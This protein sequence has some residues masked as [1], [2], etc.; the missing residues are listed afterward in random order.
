MQFIG[1]HSLRPLLKPAFP[2]HD[3]IQLPKN[4]VVDHFKHGCHL[5]VRASFFIAF[6][7]PDCSLTGAYCLYCTNS[8]TK[9]LISEE[10]ILRS[11]QNLSKDENFLSIIIRQGPRQNRGRGNRDSSWSNSLASRCTVLT[12][13]PKQVFHLMTLLNILV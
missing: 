6:P 2:R 9:I 5:Y 8:S 1:Q 3:I 4:L 7:R 11:H 10:I 12:G 13:S